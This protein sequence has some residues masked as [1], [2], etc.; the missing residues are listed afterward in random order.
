MRDALASRLQKGPRWNGVVENT[1]AGAPKRT[2]DSLDQ[3][4]VKLVFKH[5]GRA[6]V[7]RACRLRR[8]LPQPGQLASLVPP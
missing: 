4:I 2:K 3:A 6:K 8:L 1:N 7:D 5:R